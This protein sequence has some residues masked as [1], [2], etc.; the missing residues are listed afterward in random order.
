MV[1][2]KQRIIR[3]F[4]KEAK[5]RN[6]EMRSIGFKCICGKCDLAKFNLQEIKDIVCLKDS[7]EIREAEEKRGEE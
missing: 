4:E 2:Q 7:D 5:K 6:K 1:G 3:R